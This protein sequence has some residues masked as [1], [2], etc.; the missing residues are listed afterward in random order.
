M[1][2]HSFEEDPSAFAVDVQVRYRDLDPFEHVNNAV[3]ASYLEYARS[4]YL[5]ATLDLPVADYEF[6]IAGLVIDFHRP[7]TIDQSVSVHV[8]TSSVGT[9][10]WTMAYAVVAD[11]DVA[12]TGET[13]QV[14]LDDDG[15]PTPIPEATARRFRDLAEA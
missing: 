13:T 3:Y 9:S 2:D 14:W 8:G 5:E 7:V 11:G 15:D 12:A 1:T 10:S 6:V 4:E